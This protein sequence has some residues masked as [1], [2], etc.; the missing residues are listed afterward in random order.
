[1]VV[2]DEANSNKFLI[3]C[4]IFLGMSFN[5]HTDINQERLDRGKFRDFYSNN[6][7]IHLYEH[8]EGPDP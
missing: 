7:C 1:M 5:E 3:W 6:V 2:I 8:F 4:L